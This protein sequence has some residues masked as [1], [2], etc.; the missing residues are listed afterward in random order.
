MTEK[1]DYAFVEPSYV[2][3]QWAGFRVMPLESDHAL[4]EGYFDRP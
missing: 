2:D 4:V 3:D 1:L